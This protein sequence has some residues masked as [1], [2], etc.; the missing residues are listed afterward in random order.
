MAS[1]FG[2]PVVLL[3]MS[4][5]AMPKYFPQ[6]SGYGVFLDPNEK[7]CCKKKNYCNNHNARK[8]VAE[9][10]PNAQKPIIRARVLR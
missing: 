5:R 6:L 7:Y 2:V 4:F 9:I 1:Y 8:N 10:P 3:T